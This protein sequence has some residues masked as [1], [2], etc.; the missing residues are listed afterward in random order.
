LVVCRSAAALG[1]K[2][3]LNDL[4]YVGQLRSAPD[5]TGQAV[6]NAVH[7]VAP[8]KMRVDV[9]QR[10]FL[11]QFFVATQDRIGNAVVATQHDGESATAQNMANRQLASPEMVARHVDVGDDVA[12]VHE[13][14]VGAPLQ[15]RSIDVEVVM[16]RGA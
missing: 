2:P 7:F 10:N 5:R 4:A 14:D 9:Y 1:P 13:T 12:A 11:A 6:A 8:V 15:Q 3:D 16:L